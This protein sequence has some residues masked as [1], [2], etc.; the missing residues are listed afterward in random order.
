[1]QA[2]LYPARIPQRITQTIA[3]NA[4][5]LRRKEVVILVLELRG[6]RLAASLAARYRAMIGARP[7]RDESLTAEAKS[8]Q[9]RSYMTSEEIEDVVRALIT[10]VDNLETGSARQSMHEAFMQVRAYAIA[11]RA[12]AKAGPPR[13]REAGA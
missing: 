2:R 6:Y 7:R 4:T 9:I 3:P 5:T 11:I 13:Q 12:S 10:V 8:P 1:V